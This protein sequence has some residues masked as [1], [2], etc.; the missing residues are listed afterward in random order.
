MATA[1]QWLA[2][3]GTEQQLS[4]LGYHPQDL[5]QQLSAAAA[6]LVSLTNELKTLSDSDHHSDESESLLKAVQEQL[7]AAA[8]VL[9]CFA[10]PHACNNPTCGNTAGPSEA[11]L[12]GGRSCICVGCRTVRYCGRVCQRETWRRH[13]PVCKAATAA[14]AAATAA[15]A[16]AT[17]AA[18]AAAAGAAGGVAASFD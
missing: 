5:Q 9:S 13:K 16:A 14:A 8:R 18:A 1:V 15:A 12:V 3:A 10:I 2:A 4:A 7:Q 17:S 6:A 11:Q